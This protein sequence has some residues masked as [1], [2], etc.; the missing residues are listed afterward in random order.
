MFPLAIT[1]RIEAAKRPMHAGRR[2]GG[3]RG[4]RHHHRQVRV[5][6]D[7]TIVQDRLDATFQVIVHHL[8]LRRAARHYRGIPLQARESSRP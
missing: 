3:D 4:A 2:V 1:Y 5:V 6:N 8:E 7:L